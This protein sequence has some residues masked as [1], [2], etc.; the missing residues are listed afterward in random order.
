MGPDLS[1]GVGDENI[2]ILGVE[3]LN[4]DQNLRHALLVAGLDI[5]QLGQR[6]NQLLGGGHQILLLGRDIFGQA[7]RLQ[8]GVVDGRVSH[9]D[10]RIDDDTHGRD[11]DNGRENQNLRSDRH[12]PK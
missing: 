9:G 1:V 11:G 7:L 8:A 5:R 2:G 3:P 10:A 6:D 12:A 4:I